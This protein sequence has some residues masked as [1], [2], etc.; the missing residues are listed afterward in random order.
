MGAQ[1][2]LFFRAN[3]MGPTVILRHELADGAWH[4]DWLIA[5]SDT[6]G[7]LE[8]RV[9]LGF[10]MESRPDRGSAELAAMRMA[11]HRVA[12]L[13]FEGPLSGGRGSVRRIAEGRARILEEGEGRLEIE[14]DFGEGG[15]VVRVLRGTR[16]EGD[17]WVFAPV[18]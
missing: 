2:S 15:G 10:R 18:A 9:L 17:R 11:D 16:I 3:P 14:V 7:G 1:S 12:Y 8:D 4:Y 13:T 5:R 6:P